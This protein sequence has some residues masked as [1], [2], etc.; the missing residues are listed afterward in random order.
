MHVREKKIS[1]G[2]A[3]FGGAVEPLR[4]LGGVPIDAEAFLI[5]ESEIH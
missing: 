4:C 2:V 1:S 3:E 5:S